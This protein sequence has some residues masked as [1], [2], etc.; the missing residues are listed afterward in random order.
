LIRKNIDNF[1]D[2]FKPFD[3]SLLELSLFIDNFILFLGLVVRIT[4][5][6]TLIGFDKSTGLVLSM[7]KPFVSFSCLVS[8]MILVM[9]TTPAL[10]ILDKSAC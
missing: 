8:Q 10:I 6:K 2:L 9:L 4:Y 1:L 7:F 5:L 3:H